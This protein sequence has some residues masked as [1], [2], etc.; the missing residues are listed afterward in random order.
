LLDG[1]GIDDLDGGI[2]FLAKLLQGGLVSTGQRHFLALTCQ[3]ATQFGA[4]TTV[5]SND[6]NTALRGHKSTPG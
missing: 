1:R 4:N 3:S 6:D 5:G 2:E